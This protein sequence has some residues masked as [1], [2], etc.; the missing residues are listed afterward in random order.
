[1]IDRFLSIPKIEIAFDVG[2]GIGSRHHPIAF[3]HSG[4]DGVD[5]GEHLVK[6]AVVLQGSFK[7]D[8]GIGVE[9]LGDSQLRDVGK[10]QRTDIS[11]YQI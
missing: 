6:Q 11:Y 10:S 5:P 9:R 3:G 1:M 8:I 7:R 4:S 2:K